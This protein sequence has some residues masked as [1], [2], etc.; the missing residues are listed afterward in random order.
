MGL[1]EVIV[2]L[3]F[4]AKR[5]GQMSDSALTFIKYKILQEGQF[6]K[7][8]QTPQQNKVKAWD[9]ALNQELSGE[10]LDTDSGLVSAIVTRVQYCLHQLKKYSWETWDLHQTWR[11]KSRLVLIL[12]HSYY[13]RK[14]CH[15]DCLHLY[16][17]FF[18]L[19]IGLFSKWYLRLKLL[20][21]QYSGS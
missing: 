19:F 20:L 10:L 11:T 12:M 15:L 1:G 13:K 8:T 2:F 14:C 9:R 17:V 21:D 16:L 7:K 3:F 6:K 5:N 4:K 18:F